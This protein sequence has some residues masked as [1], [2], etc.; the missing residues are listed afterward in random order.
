MKEILSI[1]KPKNPLPLVFD[2]PHSGDHYPE[3]FRFSC[4]RQDLFATEDKYVEDLFASAP[5][6]G[7][8][9]LLAHFPR[10]YID[11]NRAVCDIDPGLLEEDWPF[12]EINPTARSDA[13]IGLIRRLVK[14]GMPVY[15]RSLSVEEITA[16]IEK[17]YHPYHATLKELIEESH[18]NFGQ[19][20]HINCHSMPSMEFP[21]DKKLR[22]KKIKLA[23]FVLGNRDGTTCGIDFT[24][25]IHNF[26]KK[27]GYT[28]AINDPY[29]GVELVRRHSN[30][31]RG[32]HSLQVEINRALYMDEK[33]LE[34]NKNYEA[35]KADIEKLIAFCAAYVDSQLIDLAAD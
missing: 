11:V 12:G 22:R 5:D 20:W 28:V 31:A 1:K 34:K 27:L 17:Y 3:D 29:K 24:H 35:L 8:A 9:L 16:R 13:G 21:P 14:P 30:P 18:Y 33:T 25:E 10:S 2:S 15:G 6:Y 7:G 19:V 23:D 32:L 4:D 26:L